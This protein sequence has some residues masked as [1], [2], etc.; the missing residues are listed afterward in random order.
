MTSS[1]EEQPSSTVAAR[2][3][4]DLGEDYFSYQETDA[5]TAARVAAPRFAPYLNADTMLVDYGCGTGWLLRVLD[6][7]TKIGVEPNPAARERA[8]AL[9]ISTVPSAEALDDASADV[10]VTHHA[11]EHS[12]AP[13]DD[14]RAI[15][16]VLRPGGRFVAVLPVDDWRTQ[17]RYDSANP[18]HHLYTWTPQLFTNLLKNAGF[19]VDECR[20]VTYLQPYYNGWLL[21]RL[22][23][24]AFDALAWAFG[25]AKRYRQLVAVAEKPAA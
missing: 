18:D 8:G 24:R 25:S 2:Y 9:G 17:R 19:A 4:G 12:L 23:R 5:E 3:R 16:R 13:F 20:V 10:V 7:G 14:I 11:L 21:P 6:A 15:Y 22:P 1:T